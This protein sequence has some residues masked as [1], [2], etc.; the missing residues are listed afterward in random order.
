MY[1]IQLWP[2]LPTCARNH[3]LSAGYYGPVW[4]GGEQSY[5]GQV[6]RSPGSSSNT[7]SPGISWL[8]V[9]SG[10]VPAIPAGAVPASCGRMTQAATQ[11]LSVGL[12]PRMVTLVCKTGPARTD[13][14]EVQLV[15]H[16]EPSTSICHVLKQVK[17]MRKDFKACSAWEL[18]VQVI[19]MARYAKAVRSSQTGR[20]QR[21]RLVEA[22]ERGSLL[23]EEALSSM[24]FAYFECLGAPVPAAASARLL[25]SPKVWDVCV[26]GCGATFRVQLI[27]GPRVEKVDEGPVCR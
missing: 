8:Q 24:C 5:V 17:G 2:S 23:F 13:F 25:P 27:E 9:G 10:W 26:T 20:V 19:P 7:P 16:R 3:I 15:F 14:S 18:T 11:H 6:Q 4:I 1:H 21:V 22:L 12:E